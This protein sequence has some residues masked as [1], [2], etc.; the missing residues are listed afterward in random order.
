MP[1]NNLASYPNPC[2]WYELD[3]RVNE[4]NREYVLGAFRSAEIGF[5]VS[6]N[7]KDTNVG[8]IR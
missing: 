3:L 7:K 2:V 8:V 6:R 5:E 4:E 1:R